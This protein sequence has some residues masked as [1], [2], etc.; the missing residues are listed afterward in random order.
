MRS[1]FSEQAGAHV[2]MSLSILLLAIGCGWSVLWYSPVIPLAAASVFSMTAVALYVSSQVSFTAVHT[3]VLTP[4]ESTKTSVL[5]Y[6]MFLG[7]FLS[8][9]V[10]KAGKTLSGIP[11]TISN[12]VILL[13]LVFWFVTVL[14]FRKS[15]AHIPVSKS[16]IVFIAYGIAA[17]L[18]GV[19]NNN[20]RKSIVLDFVAFIGF[21]PVY[22]L[23][24][25]LVQK[26][27]H[28]HVLVGAIVVGL[29]LVCAYGLLQ[30]RYGFATVAVPGLT[31]QHGKIMF[32]GVGRWNVIEGGGQKVYST[33]QN[34]NIFGH[35]LAT[36]VPLLGGVLL[37]VSSVKKRIAMLGILLLSGYILILTYSRGAM[38]GTASGIFTLGI[39][40]KKIRM[41]AMLVVLLIVTFMGIVLYQFA[42]RPELTRYDVRRIATD[43][44]RFSAG[45]IG[46]A[47]QVLTGFANLTLPEKLFGLGFG[48]V[49]VT[50]TG[51]RFEYVDNLYLSLLYKIGIVGMI[52][53]VSALWKILWMLLQ[54]RAQSRD[55]YFLGIINGGIAGL[56]GALVH[57]LADTLWF[58]PPLSANFWFLA[59]ITMSTAVIATREIVPEGVPAAQN[60]T[61]SVR[62]CNLQESACGASRSF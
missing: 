28:I 21:I 10:P 13:A 45:R 38:V 17:A 1:V 62:Q 50:P 33:F 5:F 30:K 49:L 55:V 15:F 35:H 54:V 19:V 23:V 12:L 46:R 47:K 40:A 42:D 11:I 36:F 4:E 53:L 8:I 14:I 39:I 41:R 37:G 22:F 57:N 58:F 48:G 32:E 31:E 56:V 51:W 60:V 29:F 34:G 3:V 6:V 16:L 25:H 9:T 52:L 20:P 26:R 7:F 59:G 18:I 44:D 27:R 2:L 61:P 24:C 43:P